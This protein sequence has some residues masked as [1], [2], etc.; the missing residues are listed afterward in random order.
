MAEL[1]KVKK[2]VM[3][4]SQVLP[5]MAWQDGKVLSNNGTMP[6]WISRQPAVNPDLLIPNMSGQSGKILSNNGARPIWIAKQTAGRIVGEIVRFSFDTPPAGFFA[7]DGSTIR[8]GRYDFSDLANCGSRFITISGNNL[9]L[10]NFQDFGRGKGSSGR[11][12]G[13]FE[14]DAIQ[15]I[16]GEVSTTHYAIQTIVSVNGAFR[17]SLTNNLVNKTSPQYTTTGSTGKLI[18]DASDSVQTA[19]ENRPKSLTEL[20]CI[21]H[22]VL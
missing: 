20:V 15:N 5:D 13:S 8:N 17:K 9:V 10:A 3:E 7:L 11:S 1:T 4:E 16:Y 18:F 12:V 2:S 19:H 14:R 22:G 21:Y 6:Q